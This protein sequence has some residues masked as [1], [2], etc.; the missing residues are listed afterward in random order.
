MADEE[1]ED[2]SQF[3]KDAQLKGVK[4]TKVSFDE[5]TL[6]QST[7]LFLIAGLDTVGSTLSLVSTE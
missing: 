1:E 4:R 5:E 3:E 2:L 6:L 7:T